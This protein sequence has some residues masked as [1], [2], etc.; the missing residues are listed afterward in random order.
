MYATDSYKA[1]HAWALMNFT[2]LSK[3]SEDSC[4]SSNSGSGNAS[5]G[6][7]AHNGSAHDGSA[8]ASASTSAPHASSAG[9]ADGGSGSGG[10]T[11]S[12]PQ[13]TKPQPFSIG[14]AVKETPCVTRAS[15]TKSYHPRGPE[16]EPEA[17]R[18]RM[19]CSHPVFGPRSSRSIPRRAPLAA[20]GAPVNVSARVLGHVVCALQGFFRSITLGYSDSTQDLLRLLTL[21]F[22]Y[23]SDPAVEQALLDGFDTVDIDM[24]LMV[25]PQIIARISAHSARV[26]SCVH[27]LLLRVGAKH[28]QALIYPLAVASHEARGQEGRNNTAASAEAQRGQ[29]AV[30]ILQAMRAHCD[31]LVEQARDLHA[32]AHTCPYLPIPAHTCPDL[33]R[34]AQIC[35]DLPGSAR[36]CPDLPRS[37]L[38]MGLL[39]LAGLRRRSLC[40]RSSFGSRSCGGRCGM[41]PSSRRTAVTFTWMTRRSTSCWRCSR[42]VL[43]P[44][45]PPHLL[46]PPPSMTFPHLVS[47]AWSWVLQPLE[48]RLTS[49]AATANEQAFIAAYGAELAA[50][51]E[52]CRDFAASGGG[53]N[54]EHLL[55]IAWEHFYGVLSQ[56]ALRPRRP[57][58]FSGLLWPSLAFAGLLWPS[59]AFSGLPWPSLTF[60][61]LL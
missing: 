33:P 23:G 29:G 37:P 52:H 4:R 14:P 41:R 26:R 1:W 20:D 36:I 38:S 47:C 45:L 21:W 24:W 55:Q 31:T 18:T 56:V 22:R 48:Q 44:H 61:S 60:S 15:N 2:A 11:V 30:R 27:K 51:L 19:P 13:M 46:P 12:P 17:T 40:R 6:N 49:G 9:D 32:S 42:C 16:K 50:G 8:C 3:V 34:S 5:A 35:P 43:F 57:P 10:H 58:A 28:P 59:L 25:L 7:S 53:A 54:A 39:T